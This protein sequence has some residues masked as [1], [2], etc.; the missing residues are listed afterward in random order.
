MP[1]SVRSRIA[2]SLV[3]F[4]QKCPI[5]GVWVKADW[6]LETLQAS[7]D[8]AIPATGGLFTMQHLILAAG[9]LRQA[10]PAAIGV[11]WRT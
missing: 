8:G 4:L 3:V 6:L 2:A 11:E 10:P 7:L 9:Q 1:R 5:K